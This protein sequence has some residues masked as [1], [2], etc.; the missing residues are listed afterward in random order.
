MVDYNII[1]KSINDAVDKCRKPSYSLSSLSNTI[2]HTLNQFAESIRTLEYEKGL[3]IDNKGN[4]VYENTDHNN[5][6]VHLNEN[7]Y[8]E[9]LMMND[10]HIQ[11]LVDN[12][13]KETEEIY[14][15][16]TDVGESYSQATKLEDEYKDKVI[17]YLNDTGNFQINIEHNHPG[18]YGKKDDTNAPLDYNVFTCLSKGDVDSLLRSVEVY[19]EN[20]KSSGILVQ[21]LVRSITAECSN[22]S[23]M[24]LINNN[25]IGTTVDSEKYHEVYNN[26][27]KKWNQYLVDV[28]RK[29]INYGDTEKYAQ[30]YKEHPNGNLSEFIHN[31]KNT[32]MKK[33]SLN[34]FPNLISDEIKAFGEL[35]FELRLD[36]L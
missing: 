26:L 13:E 18:A 22:G 29:G 2:K 8:L 15:T 30:Y 28:G 34:S 24:T 14:N 5:K 20:Y 16:V 31:D 35:G 11:E 1:V 3:L 19:G 4:V 17:K 36:W 6:L 32:Y 21:G 33:E 9:D 23:R 10:H 27:N 12:L 25:P 7:D